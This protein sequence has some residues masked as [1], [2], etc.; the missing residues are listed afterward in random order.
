MLTYPDFN[1]PFDIHTDASDSQLGAVISQHGNPVAFYS[2]KLN[3]AQR[4][5]TT[6]E[7]ELLAIVETLKEY[8]NILLGQRIKVYTDHKNLTH[9]NFNT[10]RVIRWRMVIEDF[11]PELIYIPGP[12]NV[13]ADAISRLEQHDDKLD[14]NTFSLVEE[15]DMYAFAHYLANTKKQS[16]H[17][18]SEKHHTVELA[19]LFCADK[20]PDDIYPLNFKLIQKEQVRDTKLIDY[21]AKRSEYS[22]EVF[23]GGGKS[24]QLLCKNGKIVIPKTLQRHVVEWYHTMLCHP[25]ITRTEDT[26][27]QHFTWG[28]LRDDV[29]KILI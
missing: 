27:Q 26:I 22:L 16:N 11:A 29:T 20:L 25:G 5:Y 10:Q 9:V 21:A 12:N 8:R 28:G 18:V 2:R 14:L 13:V 17:D 4:N 7:R 1:E 3:K 15:Y 24:R 6:T 19:E 23:H